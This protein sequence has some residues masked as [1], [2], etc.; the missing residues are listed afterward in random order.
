M[1]VIAWC[2][3]CARTRSVCIRV[4]RIQTKNKKNGEMGDEHDWGS[5]VHVVF[6]HAHVNVVCLL[7]RKKKICVWVD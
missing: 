6:A 3:L 4:T 7:T 5:G 2:G 1:C